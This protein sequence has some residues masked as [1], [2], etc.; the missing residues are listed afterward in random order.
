M[1]RGLLENEKKLEEKGIR[2]QFSWCK[3]WK[4]FRT[5]GL[6]YPSL[7]EVKSLTSTPPASS[8]YES[9]LLWHNNRSI[10]SKWHMTCVFL[11]YFKIFIQSTFI[12]TINLLKPYM[13][14]MTLGV[15]LGL[16]NQWKLCSNLRRIWITL[17]NLCH[18]KHKTGFLIYVSNLDGH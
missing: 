11:F 14:Q 15:Q 12:Y 18:F 9:G 8:M 17:I 7:L 2:A 16:G 4:S 13:F 1:L 10:K 6:P 5:L 3:D